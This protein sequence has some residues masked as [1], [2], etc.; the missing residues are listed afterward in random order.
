MKATDLYADFADRYDLPIT[1]IDR[2]DAQMA[3]F[4]RTL[5][6]QHGIRSVLDCACGT[7]RQLL[8]FQDM[9]LEVWGADLSPAM[10]EQ[11]RKN[12]ASAGRRIPL[13]Q[14]DYR[15]LHRVYKR[16]FD[17]VACLGA[18]GYMPDE[19]QFLRAFSSV[20]NV[21]H[22]AGILVLTTI[23]TDKQWTE[24]PRF[25]LA[26]NTPDITRLFVMDYCQ[27]IVRYQVLDIFHSQGLNEMKL[28]S[29]ELTVCLRDEQEKLLREAGFRAVEFYGGFD[30]S[31]YDKGSSTH[32]IAVAQKGPR[33]TPERQ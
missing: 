15:D 27:K 26:A 10:L 13:R 30:F 17:A 5:F 2:H 32:L 3:G 9:G 14:V 21:L 25:K 1:Y 7:G 8:L 28:W 11:A 33:T 12:I 29:A 23:T 16:K 22:E 20:K 31:D 4:F 24:K 19:A 18:I 6:D